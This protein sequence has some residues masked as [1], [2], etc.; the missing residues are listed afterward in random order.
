M[1]VVMS[2]QPEALRIAA[3][4]EYDHEIQD[5]SAS[6]LEGAS[7]L[8]R[9]YSVNADLLEA[10]E[11]LMTNKTIHYTYRNKAEEAIAKATGETK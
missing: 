1:V 8:R 9:L 3:D 5:S 4:L 6:L 10:L 2:E 7:E 11:Y